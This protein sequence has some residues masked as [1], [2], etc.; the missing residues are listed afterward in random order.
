M[1]NNR[2]CFNDGFVSIYKDNIKRGSFGAKA[3]I[4]SIN[5]LEFVVKLAYKESS[6]REEDI[7]LVE[8]QG[9]T[10]S[11]KVKTPL[12]NGIQSNYKLVHNNILYDIINIDI[13]K[14]NREMYIYC[15]EVKRL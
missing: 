7:Q 12:F 5:E 15:E 1:I 2:K 9:K 4:E 6:K 8:M 3:N 13:N 14:S 10:L 11:L